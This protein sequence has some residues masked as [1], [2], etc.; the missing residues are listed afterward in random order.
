MPATWTAVL[1]ADDIEDFDHE[2]LGQ[3]RLIWQ[4]RGDQPRVQAWLATFLAQ[5]QSIEDVSLEVLVGRWPL[6][7][8][9]AQLDDLGK[10]VGQDRLGMTDDQYRL[11]ILARILINRG[12]GRIEEINDILAILGAPVINSVEFF[13]AELRFSIAGI[14]EGS[15]IGSLI[16]EAKAGGVTLRWVWSD[17]AEEDTFQMAATIGADD[18]N[19]KSGFGDLTEATQTTGGYWSGGEVY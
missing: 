11:F 13:P 19:V 15:L 17:E 9:G 14:A 6:T 5:L 8:I 1:W 3:A 18:T 2:T 16:G 10:I 7:A 12:N 4:Y